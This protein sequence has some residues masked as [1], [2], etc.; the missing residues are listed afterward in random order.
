MQKNTKC[1]E[2]REIISLGIERV[3]RFWP[4]PEIETMVWTFHRRCFQ[5]FM[6][7]L[8]AKRNLEFRKELQK[9]KNAYETSSL[10][11]KANAA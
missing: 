4:K 5:K 2:C 11:T 1:K 7:E 6:A 10:Y 3:E 9:S 8:D